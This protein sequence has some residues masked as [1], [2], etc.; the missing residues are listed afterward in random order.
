M[1]KYH[2]S[3]YCGDY[4]GI[5]FVSVV[6]ISFLCGQWSM[7]GSWYFVERKEFDS[8]QCRPNFNLYNR[9][10]IQLMAIFNEEMYKEVND[11]GSFLT[12]DAITNRVIMNYVL[13]INLITKELI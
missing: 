11:Y 7:G 10:D 3:D 8:S 13:F 12:V 6:L 1:D 5:Q 9:I 4:G 2:G